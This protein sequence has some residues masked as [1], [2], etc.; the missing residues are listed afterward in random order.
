[1]DKYDVIYIGSG[2]ACWHGALILKMQGKKVALV[3]KELL[4]GTCT[5][6]GCDAKILLDAPIAYKEA[7]DRYQNIGLAKQAEINWNALMQY[8]KGVIGFMPNA[9]DGLFNQFGF[10][11]IRGA[12]KFIDAHT[13]EVEGKQYQADYFV[14]GTGQTYIPLDIPGKEYFKDSRDFLSLDNIP[15]HVTFV[16]AGIIGMEFAS[17]CLSFGKKV[18]IIDLAPNAL[19]QYDKKYVDFIVNKMKEQG[20]NFLF[21][22]HV[23]SL[24]KVKENEYVL[25]TQEGDEIKSNYVLVAVGRKA[26]TDGLNL[27]GLGIEYSSRGIKVDDHL[28]TKVKNIYASGDVVDKKVPK[29]T[30]T[31]EFESNYIALDILLP[32]FLKRKIT[33]PVIPNL[34]FTLPRIGQV[35]LDTNKA[36]ELGYSVEEVELGKTMSW[37]NGNDANEHLT[38]VFNKKNELVGAAILSENAGE[39]LDLLTIIINQK[40]TAKDLSKMIFSFPTVTYGLISSLL[41]LMLKK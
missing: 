6:Y 21:N 31:A 30:P 5:N 2:H 18:D 37:A 19:N 9:L 36:K 25:K 41:R 33:Y 20:A 3:E 8:K 15:D 24:E 39:Y 4:G 28:R 12:A 35:G 27:E 32:G 14:I 22:R 16:G 29:L 13:I 10:D 7:L 1:M 38:F 34:V 40:L 26:N 11:V 17:I 23:A